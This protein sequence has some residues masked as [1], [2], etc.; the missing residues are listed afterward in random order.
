ME[1]GIVVQYCLISNNDHL[2]SG[3]REG[4]VKLAVDLASV[5]QKVVGGEEVELVTVLDG[6]RV[7]DDV[8]LAAL[9]ALHGIDADPAQQRI[10]RLFE[11]TAHHRDLIAVGHNDS[12]R[13]VGIEELG[14]GVP[15]GHD[16]VR[17]DP[18]FVGVDLVA[19][20]GIDAEARR[21][22]DVAARCNTSP[23]NPRLTPSGLIIKNVFSM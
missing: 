21:N 10:T 13:S 6:E 15:H 3:A 19:L 4:N 9:I 18:C 5:F 16:H 8:A 12:H 23:T 2:P 17:R 7:D 20:F 1:N 22:E 14:V 11:Q